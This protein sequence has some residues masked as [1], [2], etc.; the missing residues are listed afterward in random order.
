MLID[1]TPGIYQW[2]YGSS[3]TGDELKLDFRG[4]VTHELG[5]WVYLDDVFDSGCNYGVDMYT[6]CGEPD[7]STT[8]DDDSWRMRSLTTHDINAANINY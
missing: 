8:V 4:V 6:M 5:H 3:H 1:P 7:N 2:W